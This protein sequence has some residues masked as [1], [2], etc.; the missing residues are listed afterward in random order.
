M[1]TKSKK[2]VI[3]TL[4]EE[5]ETKIKQLPFYD[6]KQHNNYKFGQ[7]ITA[8]EKSVN[9]LLRSYQKLRTEVT[10]LLNSRKL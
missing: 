2:E 4:L 1:S 10:T 9:D 6:P 5:T 8:L 3:E 7:Y